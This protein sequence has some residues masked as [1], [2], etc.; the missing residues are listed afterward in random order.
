MK[1][2]VIHA[3]TSAV[4]P[5]R[6]A[7]LKA[8]PEIT[9]VNLCNEELLRIVDKE[10]CV[11]KEALRM[12]AKTVFAAADAGVDGI[13]IACSVYCSYAELMQ[14]FLSVPIIAVDAP[15]VK[16]A[17]A[18]GGRIGILATTASSAP[19]CREKLEKEAE[20]VKSTGKDQKPEYE[21]GIV[22]EAMEALK[23]GNAQEHDRLLR[24]KSE[25]L[26][27]KGCTT[28]FL[29]QITMA[30]AADCLQDLGVLV[31]S[32]PDEGVE[33]LIRQIGL[34]ISDKS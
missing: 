23:A 8:D 5:L 13:M 9:L 32:T 28:L 21:E 14:N 22:T 17:V 1:I 4:A 30:R 25:E 19:A 12:F 34:K 11:T 24:L 18:Y 16:K 20:K 27:D 29:S 10:G 3:N 31:L 26:I 2:G 15:A 33:E 6:E 7:F